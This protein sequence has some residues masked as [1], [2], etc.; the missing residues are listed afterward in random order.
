MLAASFPIHD[1]QFWATT[2]I[3]LAAGAWLLRGV[4]PIPWLK[5]RRRGK[6]KRVNI[7]VGGKSVR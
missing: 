2:A 5:R 1:W 4:L 3:A 7:T 6:G